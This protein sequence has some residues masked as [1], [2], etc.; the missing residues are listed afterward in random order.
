MAI[1]SII[2]QPASNGI[3]AAYRPVVFK[4]RATRTDNNARPPVVYCDIYFNNIFYKTIAKTQYLIL[5]ATNSDWYFDIQ[6]ACQ[7]ILTKFL[8]PNGGSAILL[9]TGLIKTSFCRFRSS[10]Y[11]TDGFIQA[12]GVTP[13]QGTGMAVAV[14]G[15]GTQSNTFYIINAVLQHNNNQNLITH[16]NTYKQ[17][18]WNDTTY[19]LT[20]RTDNYNVC[21]TSSDYFPI[22]R[23]GVPNCIRINYRFKNQTVYNSQMFCNQVATCTAVAITGSPNLPN[24]NVGTPYSFTF[25]LTG[26]APFSLIDIVKPSWM[27]VPTLVTGNSFTISGTPNVTGTNV[28]VSFKIFNCSNSEEADFADTINVT[29]TCVNVAVSGSP[30]L[31]DA[32]IGESYSYDITLT[33]TAPYVLNVTTRPTWMAIALVGNVVQ[34]RGTAVAPAANNVNVTFNVTN[35]STG[36]FPFTQAIDIV[37]A[38]GNWTFDNQ[39]GVGGSMRIVINNNT[40]IFRTVSD[41][42]SIDM[43]P[44]DQLEVIVMS[45]NSGNAIVDIDGSI[46]DYVSD[47]HVAAAGPYT[48]PPGTMNIHGI[49][50]F[51]A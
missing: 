33:G 2:E 47:S 16:L 10:G 44:G 35:C 4:V 40:V 19:P 17:G 15:T 3:L 36:N 6:D 41:S 13:K 7:E 1:V 46:I 50:A 38:R 25:S 21:K 18:V 49:A 30:D 37:G 9:T 5:N 26:T 11:D 23:T 31:P 22:A 39:I 29:T 12:E 43:T 34:L 32:F 42:G 24:G 51:F 45:P 28:P 48:I 27:T 8:A 14:S 20:H